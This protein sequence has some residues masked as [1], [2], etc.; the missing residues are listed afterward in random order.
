MDNILEC[1]LLVVISGLIFIGLMLIGSSIYNAIE[2]P[3]IQ[4]HRGI[5]H[6]NSYTSFIMAG[7]VMVPIFHPAYDN[8]GDICDKHK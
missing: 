8:E 6:H 7:K 2:H 1:F 3:C 5:V 4:S